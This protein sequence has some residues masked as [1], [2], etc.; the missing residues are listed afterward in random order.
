MKTERGGWKGLIKELNCLQATTTEK[1]TNW[2][3]SMGWSEQIS[4]ENVFW[5]FMKQLWYIYGNVM[6]IS[7]KIL[8]K[9]ETVITGQFDYI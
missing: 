6:K 3:H 7:M 4:Y 1:N 8:L 9:I 2:V 5:N